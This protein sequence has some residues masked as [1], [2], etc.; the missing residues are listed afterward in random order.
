[1]KRI[2]LSISVIATLAFFSCENNTRNE[3]QTE[4]EIG[5]D[6]SEADEW[7]EEEGDREGR[8]TGFGDEVDQGTGYGKDP[9][10]SVDEEGATRTGTD[11]GMDVE[12]QTDNEVGDE[13]LE[14][15]T[16][17]S[18]MFEQRPSDTVERLEEGQEGVGPHEHRFEQTPQQD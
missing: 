2:F 4:T 3:D 17:R 5:T 7:D 12:D 14:D 6:A 13:G 9:S 11:R 10:R 18:N 15:D 8:Q 1:M 16:N